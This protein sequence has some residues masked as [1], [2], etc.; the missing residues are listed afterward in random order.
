MKNRIEHVDYAKGICILFIVLFHEQ[1]TRLPY[2][3]KWGDILQRYM[4]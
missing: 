1:V 3:E 2:A 4:L